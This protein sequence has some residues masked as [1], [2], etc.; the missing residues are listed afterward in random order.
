MLVGGRH[1]R[2]ASTVTWEAQGIGMKFLDVPLSSWAPTANGHLY[3][4]GPRPA[5]DRDVNC[6]NRFDYTT[7]MAPI[8]GVWQSLRARR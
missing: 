4:R 1:A 8:A 3:R 5:L 7:I 2:C 6:E